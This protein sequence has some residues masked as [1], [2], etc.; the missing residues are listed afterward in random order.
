MLSRLAA[1][2]A[3]ILKKQPARPAPEKGVAELLAAL[4]DVR[5]RKAARGAPVHA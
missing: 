5:A 2:V 1:P 3:T 4:A